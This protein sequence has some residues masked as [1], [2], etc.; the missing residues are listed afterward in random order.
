VA[1][2]SPPRHFIARFLLTAALAAAV[3]VFVLGP[4]APRQVPLGTSAA[5]PAL[6]GAYHIHTQQSDGALD[7]DQVALAAARAGLQFAIFTDH[8]DGTRLAPP[9]YLHG[10][11]CIDGVEVSTN[12]G[13]YVA[14]GLS[15]SPF[16]LGGE[17]DAVAEDVVRLGG[18]GIAAHPFS[19]RAELA[20]SDW[21][22]RF[23]GLEWLNADSEWRDESRAALA[24]A[25]IGYLWRPAGALAS[26]LD[27]PVAALAKWDS[28][29]ARRPV[30]GIAGLDAHGGFGEENAARGRRLHLPS[31]EAAFRTFSINAQLARPPTG[32]AAGDAA[33]VLEAVRGGRTFTAIDAIASPARLDFAANTGAVAIPMGGVVPGTADAA[34]FVVKA[35]LP[36]GG[37]LALLRDGVIVRETTEPSLEYSSRD[38]GAYRVEVRVAGAPGNPPI[39]WIVSNPIYRF[40]GTSPANTPP[41]SHSPETGLEPAAARAWRAEKS[42]GSSAVPRASS[43]AAQLTYRLGTDTSPFAALVTDF[44]V[45]QAFSRIAFRG[46]ASRPMRVSLQLRFGADGGARWRKSVYLDTREREVVVPVDSLRAADRPGALPSIVRA[47]SL[48]FVVDSVNTAPGEEG[49]FSIHQLGFRK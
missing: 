10:V 9:A 40:S 7:R 4:P 26:L 23:D 36:R 34:R 22:V 41:S 30:I 38:P 35:A 46:S 28:L 6:R 13:H 1:R 24:H 3:V 25:L 39:P 37:T 2:R 11:L 18:F 29:A 31:Y 8:G 43:A 19:R 44:A 15:S 32:N 45:P 12:Q 42:E 14:L 17:A 49:S 27:R 33:L 16:R 47:S 5:A 20:W 21:D 48:L